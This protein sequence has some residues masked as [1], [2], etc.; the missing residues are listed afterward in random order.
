MVHGLE[1]SKDLPL[2]PHRFVNYCPPLVHAIGG[3]GHFRLHPVCLTSSGDWFRREIAHTFLESHSDNSCLIIDIEKS[4]PYR[5]VDTLRPIEKQGFWGSIL[6]RALVS[7]YQVSVLASDLLNSNIKFRILNLGVLGQGLVILVVITGGLNKIAVCPTP[8][9]LINEAVPISGENFLDLKERR[10][11]MSDAVMNIII[12]DDRTTVEAAHRL[13]Q[14]LF[15]DA[16]GV[17]ISRMS[18]DQWTNHVQAMI[19]SFWMTT[20]CAE[21]ATLIRN[22]DKEG[23]AIIDVQGVPYTFRVTPSLI[24]HLVTTVAR[25]L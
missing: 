15:L 5:V 12:L 20:S 9:N 3:E 8:L 24:N 19:S 4:T 10:I 16:V 11:Q 21:Q 13:T 17:G 23:E 7:R 1:L 18:Y 6:L 22:W 14:R 2:R 25:A